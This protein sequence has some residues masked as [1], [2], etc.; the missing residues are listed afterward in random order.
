MIR[1][2]A[3]Q[4]KWSR[5]VPVILLPCTLVPSPADAQVG[6]GTAVGGQLGTYA[7][8]Y[9]VSGTDR[10][11]PA[12]TGRLY[13]RPT[14][15]VYGRFTVSF[16]FLLSTEGYTFQSSRRQSLNQYGINPQWG[17]GSANIGDFTDSYTPLT[18]SGVRVRG[19]GFTVRRG[20]LRFATVR[21]RTQRAVPGGATTGRFERNIFGG[22]I[23][24]G[25]PR[26][27]SLDLIVIKVR[28]DV[29]SLTLPEDTVLI[30]EPRPDTTF[31][32]DTLQVGAVSNPFAV[33]PQENLVLGLVGTLGLLRNALS[34]RGELT[35]SGY[36]RD[37]RADA[38][39]SER[40]LSKIPGIARAIYTP[41]VSSTVD[42]AYTLEA[43]ARLAPL[44]VSAKYRNIGPGYVSLGVASLMSDRR[45]VRLAAALRFRRWNVKVDGARQRDNL[46]GQ[47]MFTTRRTRIGAAVAVRPTR[48]WSASLRANYSTLA[49]DAV[50][51]ERLTQYESWI[52]GVNQTLRVSRRGFLRSASIAYRYRV[53]GDDNPLRTQSQSR[54]HTVNLRALASLA[55]NLN[56]TPS[57]GIVSSRF[58]TAGWTTR[59]TYAL[60]AQHRALRGRFQ[61]SLSLGRSQNNQTTALQ[62]TLTSRYQLNPRDAVT[63]TAR[64][65]DYDSVLQSGQDFREYTVNLR[66][67][68]RF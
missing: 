62:A 60:G 20:P 7:E 47:K 9:G 13:F 3:L 17:W 38:I 44:T 52:L 8:F 46:I 36:T 59:Q 14:L 51:P 30:D 23:G 58:E 25:D 48:A 43:N 27:S 53:T 4:M 68:H 32:E 41:R 29:S 1:K 35:G 15:S 55:N 5:W 63:L 45:D 18:F 57:V 21:G 24:V 67:A 12:T 33:T 42:Y 49:N 22:R 2:A 34:L 19:A 11:R 61:S 37:L 26:R 66:W 39:E 64:A 40:I 16:N 10:R 56:L 28:D 6:G 65:S 31:V 50:E 54:S